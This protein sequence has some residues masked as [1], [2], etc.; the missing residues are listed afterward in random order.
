MS[1]KL[2]ALK[3]AV[4]TSTVLLLAVASVADGQT[5]R[6]DTS[7]YPGVYLAAGWGTPAGQRF[8]IGHNCR[9]GFTYSLIVTAGD[10]WSSDPHGSMIGGLFKMH[11]VRGDREV[12]PYLFYADGTHLNFFGGADHYRIIGLGAALRWKKH[13]RLRPEVGMALTNRYVS[14]GWNLFGPDTPE[15]YDGNRTLGFNLMLELNW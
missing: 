8:E 12:R 7:A 11:L 15:V 10:N 14:G 5:A 4:M 1:R 2:H 13:L 6:V 3:K 9:W